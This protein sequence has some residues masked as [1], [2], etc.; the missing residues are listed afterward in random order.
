VFLFVCCCF[1]GA[2]YNYKISKDKISNGREHEMTSVVVV[3]ETTRILPK[4]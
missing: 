3:N 2:Y 4:N 1:C